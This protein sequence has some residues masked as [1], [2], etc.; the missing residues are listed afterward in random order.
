MS[1]GVTF[2]S[3]TEGLGTS[4]IGLLAISP[5]WIREPGQ[6]IDDEGLRHQQKDRDFN[7]DQRFGLGDDAQ[8]ND[9]RCGAGGRMIGAQQNHERA[10][11]RERKRGS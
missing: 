2:E 1:G 10:C 4:R 3:G 8:R 5:N 7:N 6:A 9:E 11:G